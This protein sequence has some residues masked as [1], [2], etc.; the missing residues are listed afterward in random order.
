MLLMQVEA[1]I[2]VA[3]QGTVRGASEVLRVG[4]PA[5]TARLA[6][7]E[8]EVGTAL[9]YRTSKGMVLTPAGNAM[10]P[11]A[12]RAIDSLMAGIGHARE[13]EAGAELRVILGAA[14]AVS[15]YVLPELLARLPTAQSGLRALVRTGHPLEIVERTLS[16][17]I[18]LGLI[19]DIGDTRVTSYPLYEE[20]LIL[21]VR[22]DHPLASEPRVAIKML[23]EYVLI[24]FDRTTSYFASIHTL[25]RKARVVPRGT[26]EVDN[27]DTAKRM[28]RRGLGVAFLPSPAAADAINDG[29][30]VSVAVEGGRPITQV[31]VAVGLRGGRDAVPR[32]VWRLLGRI[33][34]FVPGTR[35][36]AKR[37]GARVPPECDLSAVRSPARDRGADR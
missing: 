15:A 30:L 20:D 12:E 10:V 25:L 22:P 28:A 27:T 21:V 1:F 36:V 8:S 11:Y 3:R 19:P 14:P 16:G 29:S 33:P 17:D 2:Q 34:E 26:I 24:L 23:E 32:G 6:A 9:F 37:R 5:L 4:Q 31:I 13:A 18:Q 7:L 35:K